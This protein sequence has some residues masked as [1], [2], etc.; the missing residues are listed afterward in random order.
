[1]I[2]D[3]KRYGTRVDIKDVEAL[4]GLVED[5]GAD[6]G[7]LVTTEGFTQGA[8]ARAE[9][10]RGIRIEVVRIE[11]LPLWGPPLV[12]CE[13]CAGRARSDTPVRTP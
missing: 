13:A 5:V 12:N 3:C 4:A 7:L 6:M 11:D 1:M 2:V 10:E 8:K 9:A